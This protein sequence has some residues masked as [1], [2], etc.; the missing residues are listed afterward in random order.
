MPLKNSVAIVVKARIPGTH[1]GVDIGGTKTLAVA[2]DSAGELLGQ[3]RLATGHGARGVVD[4]A[5][6]ATLQVAQQIG[7]ELGDAASIGVGVPGRVDS[8]TGVV[9]H[10]VNLGFDS[11]DLGAQLTARLG[12]RVHVEND[13]NAAALGA[14]HRLAAEGTYDH[15]M[16]YLNLGTGLA[17][18]IVVGGRLRRGARGTAGEIGHISVDPAGVSCPCGQRGCL[19][20]T[21]S[22]SAILRQWPSGSPVHASPVHALKSAVDSGD[23]AA[24]QVWNG[25]LDG[26]ASAVSVLVLTVDVDKVVIGGGVAS[27]GA[28]LLDGVRSRLTERAASSPFIASLELTERVRLVPE[29]FP[30][31]GVGAA[32]VARDAAELEDA[33]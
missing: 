18:G 13:V 29:G 7:L 15:S 11:L 31:A 22:G 19:E 26:V 10:A 5:A 20:V 28:P 25:L 3:V 21:A 12:T 6:A 27:L 33:A 17:A 30:A 24:V 4:T 8:A 23:P 14:Y 1:L 9:S 16:A 2:L 32:F